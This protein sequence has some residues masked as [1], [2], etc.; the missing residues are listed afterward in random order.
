MRLAIP[1]IMSPSYFPVI[2][3]VDLG[4][5]RQCGAE[6]ELIHLFPVTAA[7][8]ALRVGEIEA[9]AGS[10]HALFHGAVDGGGVVLVAGVSR[11]MDWYLVVRSDLGPI[12]DLSDLWGLTIAA[13]PGPDGA[14]IQMLI[15]SGV[16]PKSLS[17][18]PVQDLSGGTASFG[19]TAARALN[20]GRVDGFW[21][22]GLGAEFASRLG[23]GRIIVDGRRGGGPPGA[24]RYTFASLM[25]TRQVL[26]DQA[27][28][29]GAVVAGLAMAQRELKADPSLARAVAQQRFPEEE[30]KLIVPLIAR[31]APFYDQTIDADDIAHLV[32]FATNQQLTTLALGFDDLVADASRDLWSSASTSPPN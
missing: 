16:D 24:Q 5:M 15:D 11:Y 17:I 14:L 4:Y 31:D 7:I 30:A 20:E 29:M 6:V 1:D 22:N 23:T 19:M 12:H 26:H 28:E 10:A 9:V 2:A 8:T 13:A 3:A 32:S 27:D 25:S 18:G 21:A